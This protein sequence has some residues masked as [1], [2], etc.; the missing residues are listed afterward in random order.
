MNTFQYMLCYFQ[1]LTATAL[2]F[3]A[4]H[5]KVST[6]KTKHSELPGSILAAADPSSGELCC[7]LQSS[8][9]TGMEDPDCLALFC[10]LG[11]FLT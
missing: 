5:L 7:L 1:V 4:A 10:A 6:A 8:R 11:T 3:L 2:T 9:G